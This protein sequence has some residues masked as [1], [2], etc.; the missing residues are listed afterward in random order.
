MED[1]IENADIRCG[2]TGTEIS[3]FLIQYGGSIYSKKE[4][5]KDFSVS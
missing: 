1:E 3:H 5:V 4:L 2:S